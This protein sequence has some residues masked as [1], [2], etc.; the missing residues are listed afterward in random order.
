M[1]AVLAEQHV[2]VLRIRGRDIAEYLAGRITREEV[3]KRVE[4][5][6]F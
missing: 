1:P 5:R 3:R 6:R 4:M 2:M